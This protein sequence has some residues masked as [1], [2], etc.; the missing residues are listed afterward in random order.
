MTLRNVTSIRTSGDYKY[1]IGSGALWS[2][3]LYGNALARA[4]GLFPFK[5]VFLSRPDG[6]GPR[7]G[8]PHAEAEALLSAL[9][10]GPSA[11]ATASAAPS[12]RSGDAHL[13]RRRRA[14]EARRADR[15]ARPLLRARTPCSST[16]R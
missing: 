9:S 15:R 16:R 2:W 11:S 12:G 13:P 6:D 3:F 8:D 4:L 14:G 7:D 10:A 1:V 5:D